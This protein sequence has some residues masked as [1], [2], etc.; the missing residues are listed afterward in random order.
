[1]FFFGE[2]ILVGFISY[3]SLSLNSIT[4]IDR[5]NT[6]VFDHFDLHDEFNH[7]EPLEEVHSPSHPTTSIVTA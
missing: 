4:L 6:S 7:I 1:M 5:D 2:N 3:M